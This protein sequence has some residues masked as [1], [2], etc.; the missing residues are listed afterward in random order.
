M[1]QVDNWYERRRVGVVQGYQLHHLNKNENWITR[2]IRAEFSGGYMIERTAEEF[3]GAMKMITGSV[4]MIR[5]DVLKKLGWTHS[6]TEDWDLTLR[7]Y[8][9]GYKVLYTPLIQAPAEIPTTIRALARQRM[10][11]AEGHTYAV[12]KHFWG[13]MKSQK[14]TFREKLEFLYFAPYY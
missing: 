12:K 5:A 2:G 9:D 13:I 3:F 7:M 1:E 10:R 8:M 11:W 14:I 4:F 6:I